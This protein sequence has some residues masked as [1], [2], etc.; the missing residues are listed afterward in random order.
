M[1]VSRCLSRFGTVPAG[2][3]ISSGGFEII[4]ECPLLLFDGAHNSAQLA[5]LGYA[6]HGIHVLYG[7]VQTLCVQEDQ[8]RL[9][10]RRQKLCAPQ[11]YLTVAAAL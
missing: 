8:Y 3:L 4:L 10:C 1:L 7:N 2:G 5:L 11:L 6:Q 9:Q